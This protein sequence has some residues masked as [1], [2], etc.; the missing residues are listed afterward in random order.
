MAS[1]DITVIPTGGST[2]VDL[3]DLAASVQTLVGLE[4]V[5]TV[6]AARVQYATSL[7]TYISKQTGMIETLNFYFDGSSTALTPDGGA[8]APAAQT[9]PDG[10]YALGWSS[11]LLSSALKTSGDHT[12]LIKAMTSNTQATFTYTVP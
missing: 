7:N 2:P 5:R 11:S 1:S 6:A 4:L 8:L 3:A 10:L 12:V 9:V